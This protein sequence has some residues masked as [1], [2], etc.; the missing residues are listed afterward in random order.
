MHLAKLICDQQNWPAHPEA[1]MNK[2]MLGRITMQ[3]D[4]WGSA[5]SG[6]FWPGFSRDII[7]HSSINNMKKE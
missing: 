5:V 4:N 1:H 7:L 3:V 6:E 2:E